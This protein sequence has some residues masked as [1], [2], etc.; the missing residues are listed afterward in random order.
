MYPD[1]VGKHKTGGSL[2]DEVVRAR[3]AR[4]PEARSGDGK[5]V[6]DS[7]TIALA[8]LDLL[9]WEIEFLISIIQR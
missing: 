3:V 9:S 2:V 7:P 6:L 4:S 1:V 5:S 8:A